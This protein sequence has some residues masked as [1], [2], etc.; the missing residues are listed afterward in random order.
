METMLIETPT[1]EVENWE[2][3]QADHTRFRLTQN[4]GASFSEVTYTAPQRGDETLHGT[5]EDI[6]AIV[7]ELADI[8]YEDADKKVLAH[9]HDGF[10]E[11]PAEDAIDPIAFFADQAR[12]SRE[13]WELSQPGLHIEPEAY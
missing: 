5:H 7:A 13:V 3:N 10:E 8:S 6:C 2:Y 12:Y 1:Y 4:G 11:V 9:F